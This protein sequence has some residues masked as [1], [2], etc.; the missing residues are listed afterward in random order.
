LWKERY[1][2]SEQVW[3]QEKVGRDMESWGF[4]SAGWVQDV[5]IRS[6]TIHRHSRNW[7]LEQYRWLGLPYCHML[8][9]SEIHQWERETRHP[10]FFSPEFAE[11]CDYVA[12][13]HC[14]RMAEEKNLIGYFY[15]DCPM[16]VHTRFP[17]LKQ[18]LF[19]EKK[20]KSAAGR[21]EL[22]AMATQYYKV[23]REAIRRYDKNHLILGDRYEARAPLPDEVL[24][25]AVP[26]VDVLSFQFFANADEIRHSFKRIH[27]L[28][29]RPVLLA[30][31]SPQ[32]RRGITPPSS[33]AE[34]YSS[35]MAALRDLNFCVGYHLCGAYLANRVR[36]HG[37]LA[38]NGSPVREI[39]EPVV[40][41]NKETLG[42]AAR[43]YR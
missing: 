3:I 22:L 6:A 34:G 9:F 21:E 10:D 16:W 38:E 28:T 42:W 43:G 32:S 19:E 17:E 25:A 36:K 31:S 11:W 18:P 24:R 20:L 4:N 30:D 8:P 1:K 39:L 13:D 33:W 35:V 37:L 40:Q 7:A 5:V 2:N 14:H 26:Y 27:D 41:V 23:T 29:G 15:S 12:R